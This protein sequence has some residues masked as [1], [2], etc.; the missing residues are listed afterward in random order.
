MAYVAAR[1]GEQ[2]IL[3]AEQL[4]HR[5]CGEPSPELVQMISRN[6]PYLLDRAMSEGGL[7]APELAALAVAQSGGDLYEAVLLLRAYTSTQPRLAYAEP[8]TTETMITVRRISSAFKDIPGG[9]VLGPTL[10]YS[11]RLLRLE[12]LQDQDGSSGGV[13]RTPAEEEVELTPADHPAPATYPLVADWE[14]EQGLLSALPEHPATD[15]RDLPDLTRQPMLFP[16]PRPHRLQ[17]LARADTGGL[18]TLAY[19][20]MRGFGSGGHSNVNELRL[21]YAEVLLRHPVSGAVFSAGRIRVSQGETVG[22]FSG[23]TGKELGLGFCATLGWNEAKLIA[24]ATLDSAMDGQ[25][26]H[27]AHTEEF[28]LYHTE[29]MEASG[30]VLHWKLPHYVT[31]ASA[32]DNL[33]SARQGGVVKEESDR[34]APP[35]EVPQ[36][37]EVAR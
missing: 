6:M 37:Q 1:G 25:N 14:R 8:V 10:D 27:P 17:A 31:F 13:R 26:V 12:L 23:D 36:P 9:Q 22:A 3:Q 7:Y 18:M 32:L 16:A 20:S 21:G 33:R 34:V 19:S 2:A 30:F 29:I 11:H 28:V 35:Q 5:L 15:P 4:H 24:G